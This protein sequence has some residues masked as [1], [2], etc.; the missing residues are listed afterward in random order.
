MTSNSINFTKTKVYWSSVKQWQHNV[1][2]EATTGTEFHGD[3]ISTFGL[4]LLD[5][6][7]CVNSPLIVHV[8]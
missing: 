4:L 3:A 5:Y 8:F 2:N 7:I 6:W 1:H